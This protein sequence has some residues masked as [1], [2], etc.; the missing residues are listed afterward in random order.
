VNVQIIA[1][2]STTVPLHRLRPGHEHPL[3]D[4][5]MRKSYSAAETRAMAQWIENEGVIQSLLVIPGTVNDEH[6]GEDLFVITG[7]RRL[8]GLRLLLD[9][10]KIDGDYLVPVIIRRD[11]TPAEALTKS[12]IE[13]ISQVPPHPVDRYEAFALQKSFGMADADIAARYLTT[14]RI[15]RQALALGGLA[16]EIRE[17]WRAG[18]INADV[19][20]AFTLCTDLDVQSKLYAR[21][22]QQNRLWPDT[23]E[24]ELRGDQE[25]IGHLLV[26]VG[27][28]AYVNAGGQV[29]EDL[30]RVVGRR[31]LV[32]DVGLLK[33]MANDILDRECN[34]LVEVDGWAW[35]HP[36]ETLPRDFRMWHRT[37][38]KF[39]PT[40]EEKDEIA[41]L[42]KTLAGFERFENE[43]S[44][45][46]E[47]Q[48]QAADEIGER[49]EAMRA[50]V[51]QR[52]FSE[53]AKKK[54]GCVLSV[55]RDGTVQIEHG[56]IRPAQAKDAPPDAPSPLSSDEAP[57]GAKADAGEKKKPEGPPK[58]IPDSLA[59][60]L[61]VQLTK[62][63]EAAIVTEPEFAL[64]VLLAALASNATMGAVRVSHNGLGS[65][66]LKLT[67]KASFETM[68]ER[69]ADRTRDQN[70]SL[71]AEIAGA[72][73]NFEKPDAKQPALKVP[74]VAAIVD[75]LPGIYEC[76]RDRFF[77]AE[78]YFGTAP[79]EICLKAIAEAC[80]DDAARARENKAKS[81]ILKACLANVVPTGW[82]PPELRIM[83]Y[84][85]KP[86]A[87]TAAKKKDKAKAPKAKP[88]KKVKRK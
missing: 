20:E 82:L 66:D 84:T 45:L 49:L 16:P 9:D 46:T 60:R 78:D 74:G 44:G 41:D 47:E 61:S 21:L 55:R 3:G 13:N 50:S 1:P 4:V 75:V 10:A 77:D 22:K 62:A 85:P 19:A 58:T 8:A 76:L 56:F 34:R 71:L 2:Q 25:E 68:V 6:G 27:V 26:C 33:A 36:A 43:N 70:L 51:T 5:N 81:E 87:V 72:A 38:G 12:V 15:V 79:K 54:A 11:L 32:T 7:G 67:D 52:G 24:A 29:A 39:A 69:F 88:A 42:E 23:I 63:A 48:D 65:H 40:A 57:A 35:A 73:L 83:G 86:K 80:G 14:T 64:A 17:D 30:F 59:G 53:R 28:D 18:T 37:E 31:D